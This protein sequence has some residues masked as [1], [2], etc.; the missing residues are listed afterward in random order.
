MTFSSSLLDLILQ[1][2]ETAGGSNRLVGDNYLSSQSNALFPVNWQYLFQ[3][4]D[5]QGDLEF[6]GSYLFSEYGGQLKGVAESEGYGALIKLAFENSIGAQGS[7]NQVYK[8]WNAN[9][10][11]TKVLF[12]ALHQIVSND[13]QITQEYFGLNSIFVASDADNVK[14]TCFE[15]FLSLFETALQ[16]GNQLSTLLLEKVKEAYQT[17]STTA[18]QGYQ[19]SL[20]QKDVLDCGNQLHRLLEGIRQD[21]E[22]GMQPQ[23]SRRQENL[24]SE[25]SVTNKADFIRHTD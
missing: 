1:D 20:S 14:A 3:R 19:I 17:A 11:E 5:Y 13:G 22:L 2:K 4:L 12:D 25:S 23:K 15:D 9:L 16:M 21:V 18:S 8:Q 6:N 10:E 7:M 24:L